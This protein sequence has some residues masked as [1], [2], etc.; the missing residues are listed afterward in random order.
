M[1]HKKAE[2]YNFLLSFE[3]LP[4]VLCIQETSNKTNQNLLHFKGYKVPILYRRKDDQNG[5]GVA[6][7]VKEGLD[8]EEIKYQQQNNNIE[9]AFVRIFGTDCQ[10]DIINYYTNGKQFI[11]KQDYEYIMGHVSQNFIMV[12]DFNLRDS[13]WDDSFTDSETDK[14]R[15]LIHFMEDNKI[16][17]LI[18]GEPTHT[19]ASTGSTSALDL[20][21]AT[22][23]VCQ[24]HQWYVHEDPFCS[25]HLPIVT[26]LNK[27]HKSVSQ[28]SV[29]RWKLSDADW[30][31]FRKLTKKMKINYDDMT[32]NKSNEQ[33]INELLAICNETVPK[34]KPNPNKKYRHLPWWTPECSKLVKAK[35][36]AY[37]NGENTTLMLLRKSIS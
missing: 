25:D 1:Q 3:E 2:F 10:I 32:I 31:L 27:N 15:E 22:R 21:L 13:L 7:I 12:G 5:G 29:P 16:I 11:S 26:I 9:A 17:I 8:S 33:F 34:T 19:E 14:S 37:K 24:G 6:I 35:Q 18:N 20:T 23:D 30:T 4:E 36:K 28:D